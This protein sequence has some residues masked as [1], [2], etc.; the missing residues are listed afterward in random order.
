MRI[1]ELARGPLAGKLML[2]LGL[3]VSCSLS[4]QSDEAITR[5]DSVQDIASQ[6]ETSA[7]SSENAV[8]LV[9]ALHAGKRLEIVDTR[10]VDMEKDDAFAVIVVNKTSTPYSFDN[11]FHILLL[12]DARVQN[13][14]ETN[15]A[16]FGVA[17]NE[18]LSLRESGSGW[19]EISQA[20]GVDS[21]VNFR[22]VQ[23][24]AAA[25]TAN[26]INALPA[27]ALSVS[28]I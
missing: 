2:V 24:R 9:Q 6:F 11:V 25:V 8:A 20:F 15:L 7:G 3:A 23:N 1:W 16:D 19:N 28:G 12:A 4:A 10:D 13:G 14:E 26:P 22:S 5:A 27:N 18:V 17:I 21:A